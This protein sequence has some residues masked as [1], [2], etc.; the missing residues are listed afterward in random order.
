VLGGPKVLRVVINS[1]STYKSFSACTQQHKITS[2]QHSVS[3]TLEGRL[4]AAQRAYMTRQPQTAELRR[5]R[6]PLVCLQ[7]QSDSQSKTKWAVVRSSSI[8]FK[9]HVTT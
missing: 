2:T 4:R 1:S 7:S 9:Y 5:P 6:F 8:K 3:R